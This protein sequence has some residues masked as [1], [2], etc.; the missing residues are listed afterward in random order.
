MAFY[1]TERAGPR[2][3]RVFVLAVTLTAVLVVTAGAVLVLRPGVA[4]RRGV[5]G[6]PP[7]SWGWVGQQPVP[8]SSATGPWQ[9]RGGLA[10]GYAHDELGAAVAAINIV[11]RL[12]AE[13]GP[14]VYE[15][16]A[17]QQCIGDPAAL[18]AQLRRSRPDNDPAATA[19]A[20]YFYR[21]VNGDPGGEQVLM[22]IAA[23][24]AE[25]RARGG[26]VG[27]TVTLAWRDDD[28]R[29][30]VPYGSAQVVPSTAGYTLLGEPPHV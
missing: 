14:R 17:R 10:S 15:P 16:T 13:A 28:W 19:P 6:P 23:D 25:G 9:V 18:I 24:T 26:L 7:M 30:V 5:D 20:A 2:R 1:M 11:T 12:S 27:L 29:L 22:A 3:S 4:E 8:G 21:V